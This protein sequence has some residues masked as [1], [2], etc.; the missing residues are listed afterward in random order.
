MTI[1]CTKTNNN[2][3]TS[4]ADLWATC[5]FFLSNSDIFDNIHLSINR[6]KESILSNNHP[7]KCRLKK[8]IFRTVAPSWNGSQSSLRRIVDSFLA[9]FHGTPQD[10]AHITG[11]LAKPALLLALLSA[12]TG[13]V[14]AAPADLFVERIGNENPL[15]GINL[16]FTRIFSTIADVDDDGDLDI[17][18]QGNQTYDNSDFTF[19]ENT[20]TVQSPD[21]VR[22]TTTDNPF[23]GIVRLTPAGLSPAEFGDFDNDGDLDVVFTDTTYTTSL[24][25]F[26]RYLKND[27]SGGLTEQTGTL[28]PLDGITTTPFFSN[29]LTI[30]DLDSDGDL[31]ILVP[32]L[33][34]NEG[35]DL[36][37]IKNNGTPGV[38]NM[39][40]LTG[41]SNPFNGFAFG[42]AAATVVADMDDNGDLDVAHPE[43]DSGYMV[44]NYF[45]N[46]GVHN[47][48]YRTGSAN[49]FDGIAL[50]DSNSTLFTMADIDNDGDL[51]MMGQG[52]YETDGTTVVLFENTGSPSNP[53]FEQQTG[54]TNPFD[55]FDLHAIANGGPGPHFADFDDDG[56]LDYI[57]GTYGTSVIYSAFRYFENTTIVGVPENSLTDS[58]VEFG[59]EGNEL[60][61][62]EFPSVR[63]TK[64]SLPVML[65]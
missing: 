36:L 59:Y 24:V 58:W 30:S 33:Y 41:T 14:F 10:I 63:L 27:G 22:R 40:L 43:A 19:L 50:D 57:I 64:E 17:V 38:P 62:E 48:A 65:A 26:F 49:P 56:D 45:E 15:N 52:I 21:F 13:S 42:A 44:V 29:F 9:P 28:N 3:P 37:F 39:S 60:G 47:M 23:Y 16:E 54:S 5:P 32:G 51:D 61:T 4:N 31:D 46:L 2:H 18:V 12:S 6:K 53:I 11:L 35:S 7:F 20:G 1:T 34:T 8:R 25:T 55:G